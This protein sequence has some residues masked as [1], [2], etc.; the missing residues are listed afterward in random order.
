MLE[1]VGM[2]SNNIGLGL[3]ATDQHFIVFLVLYI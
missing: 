1:Y 3:F 2:F